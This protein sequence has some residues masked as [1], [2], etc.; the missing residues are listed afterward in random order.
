MKRESLK[1]LDYF[2]PQITQEN[3]I[4]VKRF[5]LNKVKERSMKGK[6]WI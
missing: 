1:V 2:K 5:I 3:S 6:V 4:L